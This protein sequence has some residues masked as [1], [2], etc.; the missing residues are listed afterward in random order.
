MTATQTETPPRPSATPRPLTDRITHD[1][2]M[3]VLERDYPQG[4]HGLKLLDAPSGAGAMSVRMRNFG[5][6]VTCC[7]IDRGNFEAD[8]FEHVQADLNRTIDLPDGRFDVVVSIAG[9]QRLC[10]AQTAVSE[11]YRVLKPG[12]RLY[13]SV[14]NFATLRKRIRFFLFGTLGPRFDQP[15]YVQTIEQPE[16][17]FRFPLMYP[18]VE[19][20]V[21]SAGFTLRSLHVHPDDLMRWY[22][23]PLSLL[24]WSMSR[25]RAWS[26]PEKAGAYPRS[27]TFGMLGSSAYLIVAEKK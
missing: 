3:R 17:N 21:T 26:N 4:G 24:A 10:F 12:G 9:L 16:A 5:F 11:F 20:M 1:M 6:N 2:V 15:Q 22:Y 19:H 23:L 18:H 14:P 25:L 27:T 13:L 7:D 8:G